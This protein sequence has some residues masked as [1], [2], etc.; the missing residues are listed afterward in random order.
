MISR[1]KQQQIYEQLLS[2]YSPDMA[3]AFLRAMTDAKT[4][5]NL[6]DLTRL[7][8][9]DDLFGI[10]EMLKINEK[11]LFPLTEVARETFVAGGQSVP[12]M[13]I[14]SAVF[15]FNGNTP[16]AA[17]LLAENSGRMITQL[18]EDVLPIVQDTLAIAR[19]NRQ[20]ARKTALD[21]IGR[22]NPI[23]KR[24]EGGLIG[25][26]A[27]QAKAVQTMRKQLETLDKGYFKKTLRDK[28]FDKTVL[29]AIE[30]GTPLTKAQID[31]IV[32]RY[33]DRQMKF[34]A[35]NV[36]RF[37][38]NAAL[39]QGQQ[40]SFQQLLDEGQIDGVD[41]EWKWNL[42]GQEHPRIEH[43]QMSGTVVD[44]EEDF[45]FDDG[46]RMAHPHDPRGGVKHSLH[47]RCTVFY[48]PRIDEADNG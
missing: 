5:V 45:V 9:Q 32:A 18:S 34:R 22:R 26:N 13:F 46:T 27:P 41:K 47:C 17:Q 24:R 37:E 42:G 43:Q 7:I 39:S 12:D 15:G 38:T 10:V 23:T 6:D 33:E 40:E 21:L 25:L 48:S 20:G 19:E 8:E 3:N 16:R 31:K 29:K 35:E 2:E 28:R 44:F 30:D 1:R 36:A 14:S 4:A 11:T